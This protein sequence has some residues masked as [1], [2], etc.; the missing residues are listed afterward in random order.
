MYENQSGEFVCGY[1]G[2]KGREV[3]IN[4]IST[5]DLRVSN[6]DCPDQ[7]CSLF[8]NTLC[9]LLDRHAPV[10]R[11]RITVLPRVPWMTDTW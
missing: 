10:M 11:Q 8:H 5:S 3:F 2:L 6:T 1:W 4:E 9:S 7:L